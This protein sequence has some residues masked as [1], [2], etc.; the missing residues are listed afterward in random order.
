[1]AAKEKQE[2]PEAPTIT[3][4]QASKLLMVTDQWLRVLV[5]HGYIPKAVKDRYE[6]G[7]VS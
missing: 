2:Q 3:V 5:S 4:A 1:M 7:R 6:S